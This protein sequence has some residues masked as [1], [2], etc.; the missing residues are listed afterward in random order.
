MPK[1]KVEFHYTPSRQPGL[2]VLSARSDG[3]TIFTDRLDLMDRA[4]RVGFVKALRKVYP[5]VNKEYAAD[6]LE[7]LAGRDVDVEEERGRRSQATLLVELATDAE[8]FHDG[9]TAY[10]TVDVTGSARPGAHGGDHRSHR[11][12]HAVRQ[13]GFRQWLARRFYLSH[14]KAPGSQ[15]MQ[16]AVDL[17]ASKACLEGREQRAV[18]RLAEH[19]GA[20]YLD[21]ADEQWRAVKITSLG[22]KIVTNPP[23]K[24][25]RRRGMLS[26]PAP[27]TGGTIDELRPLVNAGGRANW[28]LMVAWLIGALRAT[29]PYAVLALN[30][31]QGSAKTTTSRMLRRL[32]DPN[33]ADARSAPRTE[34]DLMIAATNSWMVVFD[35][36]SRVPAHLSDALCRLSTGGGFATRELY[37][38]DEE[39]LFQASRP[40]LF[41]GIEELATRPDLLERAIVLTLP[42]IRDEQ[43]KAESAMW[44]EYERVRPRV[45]GALLTAASQACKHLPAVKL[46]RPPRMADFATWVVAAEPALPWPAGAF[47][48]AYAGNRQVASVSAV[49]ASAIGPL[50]LRLMRK[51]ERWEGT[52]SHLLMKLGMQAGPETRRRH[53]WPGSAK[54]LAGALRRLAPALP[55]VGLRLKLLG[56]DSGGFRIA[57][58]RGRKQ[59]TRSTRRAEAVLV[60]REHPERR[61][62]SRP[63][64]SRRRRR[65][66]S[67]KASGSSDRWKVVPRRTAIMPAPSNAQ[68]KKGDIT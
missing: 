34:Q 10:A 24:F 21:L 14:G 46:T 25:V 58:E 60:K 51:H 19:Q 17:I 50:V 36:L 55:S 15:A 49:D 52:Y 43:R 32:I 59:R 65:L 53:D 1:P 3:K 4:A 56:R 30:G 44:E 64:Q 37:S 9:G 45:L 7:E 61:E 57:L 47:L 48:E 41:N 66:L 23:V 67:P 12:T 31:Q 68:V 22:W 28:R 29:G 42:P 38:N 26:L 2:G 11:E 54:A 63:A 35:N 40:I 18:V 39:K 6:A 5:G 33:E 27:V 16:E 13:R 20:I 62:H 8:L